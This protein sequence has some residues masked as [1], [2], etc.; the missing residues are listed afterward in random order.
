MLFYS[1]RHEALDA[2]EWDKGRAEAM[3][4]R[5]VSDTEARFDSN[6]FWPAHP[7]D[8]GEGTHLKYP[9]TTLYNGACGV[10]WA[11]RYLQAAGAAALQVGYAEALPVLLDTHRVSMASY[12]IED[13]V[14][15]MMGDTPIQLLAFDCHPSAE[16]GDQLAAA[17]ERNLDNPTRE[18]MWGAPGTMLA[19]LFLFERTGG[20]CWAKLFQAS[21]DKLWSELHWSPV[22]DC[23]HWTQ[24]LYGQTSTYL[25]AVHGFAGTASVLIR[26]RHLLGEE[27]W[28]DWQR[29]IVNT[30]RRAAT[31]EGGEANWR[32]LLDIPAGKSPGYLMQICHGAPG[33][34]VCV[35]DIRSEDLDPLLCAAGEAIWTAGPL[36][37]GSNLCHGTAGNGYAFL[38]LHQRTGD[39]KWLERARS[40]AMHAIAQT[41]ADA[42]RYGQLRYSLWTGDLGFAIFLHDC[43]R[44]NALFPTLDAFFGSGV[45]NKH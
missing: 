28:Q 40:F 17:F 10:I 11:L 44:G 36:K 30:T 16:L 24:D 20:D 39:P 37:K 6:A 45:S 33:F 4:A 31:W 42:R 1:D 5:I 14:S 19:A 12:G 23:Q 29:C 9:L 34:I 43:I 26:G 27:R 7:L 22:Y 8:V 41:E 3:I 32:V 35:A 38:K 21:A 25:G 13:C 2:K 15:Y 18:L